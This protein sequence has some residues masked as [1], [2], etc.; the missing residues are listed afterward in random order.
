MNLYISQENPVRQYK[1]V[2]LE[3]HFAIVTVTDVNEMHTL[4]KKYSILHGCLEE[5]YEQL[6]MFVNT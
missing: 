2:F 5:L 4:N 1:H 6:H 3:W